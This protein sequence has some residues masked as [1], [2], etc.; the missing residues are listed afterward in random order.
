MMSRRRFLQLSAG[1]GMVA[2]IGGL[3]F[4]EA[5]DYRALVCV[6]MFGGNDG[7][8]LVVP[9]NGAQYGAYQSARGP[10]ALPP[11]QLLPINDPALGAFGLHYALPELQALFTQGKLAIV[12]NTGVLA[13]PTAY[14]NLSDPTFQ[15]PSNLRSHADQVIMMQTGFSDAGGSSGWGGRTLDGLE[16]YNS[17]TVFPISISMDNPAIYC[18]GAVTQGVTLQPT[19]DLDQ[20]AFGIYPPAAAQARAAAQRQ[21]VTAKGANAIVNAANQVMSDATTLNPILK[22]AGVGATF[23]KAFPQTTI[24]DQLQEIARIVS[25]NVQLGVGR[26]VFFCGLGGFDTHGGQAYQQWDLLQRTS[27]ALDAFYAALSAWGMASQVTAFTMSDFG[28]TLQPSG[29]GTDHGW[30]NH[31]LVLG[32]AVN[33]GRIYGR[34]PLM[35][36]YANFNALA[37]DYADTRGTMLPSTSLAQYGATLARWFGATEPQL[38]SIFPQLMPFATRDLGFMA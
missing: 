15:L 23:P 1:L 31:H 18:V 29:S 10:L 37:D 26:Q 8:N 35:T 24:G 6:F 16:V 25:L 19:N 12:A 5:A 9:L 38:D 36:N 14:R 33:G 13:Q 4:A 11:G 34:F 20:N 27:Q 28:R 3:R 7:H 17:G 21:I 22:A 30:G 32:G 2:G